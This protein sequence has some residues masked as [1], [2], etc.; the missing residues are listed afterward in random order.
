[1]SY[2]LVPQQ[3]KKSKSFSKYLYS[4]I[5]LSDDF[6]IFDIKLTNQKKKIKKKIKKIT[7]SKSDNLIE[8]SDKI[9]YNKYTKM[10]IYITSIH[11]SFQNHQLEFK[12]D[13]GQIIFQDNL[14]YLEVSNENGFLK[15]YFN[16]ETYN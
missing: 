2:N 1:M 12:L 10:V 4:S 15:C 6:F 13:D 8:I 5:D 11:N 9:E 16:F 14:I 3:I 7:N